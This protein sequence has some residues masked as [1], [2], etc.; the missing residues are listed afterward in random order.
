MWNI[1]TVCC[2]MDCWG[3]THFPAPVSAGAKDIGPQ[4]TR[5]NFMRPVP[6]FSHPCLWSVFLFFFLIK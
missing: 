3:N 4:H 2:S 1:G 5:E 6:R